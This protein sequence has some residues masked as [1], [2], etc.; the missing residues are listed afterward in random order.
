VHQPQ[1]CNLSRWRLPLFVGQPAAAEGTKEGQP[2]LLL[3][4][5]AFIGRVAVATATAQLC[6]HVWTSACAR[7]RSLPSPTPLAA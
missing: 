4:H 2:E 6:C 3:Q 5:V 7:N 1:A